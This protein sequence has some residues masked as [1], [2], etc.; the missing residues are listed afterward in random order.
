MD[1]SNA[2]KAPGCYLFKNS[3]G[4]VIYVGKAKNLYRR[5]RQYFSKTHE[6]DDKL[7]HLVREAVSVE[8]RLTDSELDALILEYKLIKQFRP[9][10]NS[11]LKRD[12][13]HPY[14]KVDF[15]QPLPTLYPVYE[16]DTEEAKFYGTFYHEDDLRETLG[17]I[18]RIW[19]TPTCEKISFNKV[20][21]PCLN[22]HIKLCQA[23]C[24]GSLNA[25]VYTN[26]IRE[27][28]AYLDTG[29]TPIISELRQELTRYADAL[30]FEKAAECKRKLEDLASLKYKARC[31]FRLPDDRDAVIAI[32]PY[33]AEGISLFYIHNAAAVSR[34]DFPD[35]PDKSEVKDFLSA[36]WA[37]EDNLLATCLTEIHAEKRLVLLEKSKPESAKKLVKMLSELSNA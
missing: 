9:W 22:S 4:T 21:R 13:R 12:V 30:E 6:P 20:S 19:K 33:R 2:P 37:P 28:C 35:I 11:Q 24:S 29:E 14:L 17:L 27:V 15:S 25:E 31:V 23:P 8:Y 16:K 1:T 3:S 34:R 5:V 18:Q 10:Y 32:R 26:T 36:E 7:F